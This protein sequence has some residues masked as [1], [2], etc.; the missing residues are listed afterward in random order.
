[1]NLDGSNRTKF[2]GLLVVVV[3]ALTAAIWSAVRGIRGPKGKV[4]DEVDIVSGKQGLI[5]GTGQE[6]PQAGIPDPRGA[7]G[8]EGPQGR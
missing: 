6:N 2:V 1:M 5:D 3:I 7:G 8:M 4:V